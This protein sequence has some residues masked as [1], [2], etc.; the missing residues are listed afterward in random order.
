MPLNIE[1][2]DPLDLHR[3]KFIGT[4]KRIHFKKEFNSHRVGLG[5]QYGRCDAPEV[6]KS[7]L[8]SRSLLLRVID[9]WN[10][11]T[12]SECSN[13]FLPRFVFCLWNLRTIC[14]MSW[15]LDRRSTNFRKCFRK[16]SSLRTFILS[17]KFS[18]GSL[19]KYFTC[20]P[21]TMLRLQKGGWSISQQT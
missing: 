18:C 2:F 11:L 6:V 9:Y 12:G 17:L 1:R 13:Y 5:H 8:P 20:L 3:C 14:W 19:L 16:S 21:P 7:K 10:E 4:K 15:S